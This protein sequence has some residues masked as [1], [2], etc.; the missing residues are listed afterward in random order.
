[1]CGPPNPHPSWSCNGSTLLF[2]FHQSKRYRSFLF[3]SYFFPYFPL[4]RAPT[5]DRHFELPIGSVF[6]EFSTSFQHSVDNTWVFFLSFFIERKHGSLLLVKKRVGRVLWPIV[7]IDY[8]RVGCGRYLMSYTFKQ[9][10]S[11]FIG[12]NLVLLTVLI[13]CDWIFIAVWLT[14]HRNVESTY[15]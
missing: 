15:C 12:G 7:N 11:M 10:D 5:H 8:S 13:V 3:F 2:A 9:V 14:C 4:K 6:A 1:M